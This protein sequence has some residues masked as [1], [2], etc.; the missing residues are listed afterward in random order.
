MGGDHLNRDNSGGNVCFVPVLGVL[1][2]FNPTHRIID[3]W[4]VILVTKTNSL[5]GSA[6]KYSFR[7]LYTPPFERQKQISQLV[8]FHLENIEYQYLN[9]PQIDSKYVEN[10]EDCRMIRNCWEAEN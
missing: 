4:T 8:L 10:C 2:A 5:P 9:I 1:I 7:T 6:G 3:F